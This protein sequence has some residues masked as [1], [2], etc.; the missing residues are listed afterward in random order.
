VHWRAHASVYALTA[1]N[2]QP[3]LGTAAARMA[4]VAH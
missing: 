2:D 1:A 3:A 4:G